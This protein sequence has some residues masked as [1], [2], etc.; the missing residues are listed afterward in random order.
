MHGLIFLLLDPNPADP[1]NQEAAEVMRND[2]SRF[3]QM[4]KQSLRGSTV[5]GT[6]FTRNMS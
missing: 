2:I 1:L 4:V 6:Q 3:E 5:Q